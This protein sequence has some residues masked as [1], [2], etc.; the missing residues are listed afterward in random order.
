MFSDDNWWP[1]PDQSSAQ[2]KKISRMTLARIL[3]GV[4]DNDW[5]D[6][7]STMELHVKNSL[8]N[9]FNASVQSILRKFFSELKKKFHEAKYDM[10]TFIT[11]NGAWLDYDYEFPVRKKLGG[12]PLKD[13]M[14]LQLIVA[15]R[16]VG[17]NLL[18]RISRSLIFLLHW[19]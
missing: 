8:G 17:L 15:Q 18:E 16:K 10:D 12:R 13:I 5:K 19:K 3:W 9:D 7:R 4:D 6:N 11:K 14:V 2:F 1:F